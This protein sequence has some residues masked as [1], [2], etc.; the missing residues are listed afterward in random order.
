MRTE[1]RRLMRRLLALGVLVVALGFASSDFAGGT[2]VAAPCCSS[3][4]PAYENCIANCGGDPT[5][6]TNCQNRLFSCYRW[7]SF[8]C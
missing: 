6:E 4:D 2:T 8:S 3:C 1:I 5:C 7:C